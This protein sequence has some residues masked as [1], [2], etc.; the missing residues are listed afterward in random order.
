[1]A[2]EGRNF[3]SEGGVREMIL[4]R[5]MGMGTTCLP[6]QVSIV[7]FENRVS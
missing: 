1:M 2:G 4:L 7:H 3:A 6:V 5:G